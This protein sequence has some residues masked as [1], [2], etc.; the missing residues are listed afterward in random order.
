MID[1]GTLIDL[2]DY[3]IMHLWFNMCSRVKICFGIA[4]V[5]IYMHVPL[6]LYVFLTYVLFKNHENHF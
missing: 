3:L 2:C 6:G 5:H 1:F 4:F